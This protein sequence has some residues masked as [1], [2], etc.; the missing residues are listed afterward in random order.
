MFPSILKACELLSFLTN[1]SQKLPE[2]A[3]LSIQFSKLD[4]SP[5]GLTRDLPKGEPARRL[6]M[7]VIRFIAHT[8]MLVIN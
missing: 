5:V 4:G 1:I 8:N 3:F 2:L 7:T 6:Y